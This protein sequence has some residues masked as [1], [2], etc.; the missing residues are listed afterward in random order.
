MLAVFA[1]PYRRLKRA[2]GADC[3]RSAGAPAFRRQHPIGPY[4]LDFY[5]A[6]ARLAV[7]IGGMSHELCDRPKRDTRRDG[8]LKAQGVTVMRIAAGEAMAR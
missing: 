2:C 1:A 3:A 6:N 8:W 4:V 7:E 5:C